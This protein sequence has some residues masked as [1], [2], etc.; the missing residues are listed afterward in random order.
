MYYDIIF[1]SNS[2]AIDEIEKEFNYSC[3]SESIIRIGE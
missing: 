2:D 3:S 1:S